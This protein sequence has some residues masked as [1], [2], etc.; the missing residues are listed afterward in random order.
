MMRQYLSP[1]CPY[2]GVLSATTQV[3][4]KN[5]LLQ[6]FRN[7]SNNIIRRSTN[8][9]VGMLA[10]SIVKTNSWPELIPC[11][12]NVFSMSQIEHKC[13]ALHVLSRIA[14]FAM[15]VLRSGLRDVKVMLR[16]GLTHQNITVK[17]AALKTTI[18]IMCTLNENER[19]QLLDLLNLMFQVLFTKKLNPICVARL[20]SLLV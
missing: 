7:E 17:A 14:E 15:D 19:L 6:L 11:M 9:V 4:I 2:W 16:T 1:G 18:M 3:G 12:M 5:A 10:G 13:S 8:D 20:R